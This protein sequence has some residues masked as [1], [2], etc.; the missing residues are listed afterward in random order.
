MKLYYTLQYD[1]ILYSPDT[2]IYFV[3]T[4]ATIATTYDHRVP[5]TDI[6]EKEAIQGNVELNKNGTISI[7]SWKYIQNYVLGHWT[8]A[9]S[10]PGST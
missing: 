4:F 10:I 5:L 6:V 2:H 1:T 8:R 3:C 9:E 7:A